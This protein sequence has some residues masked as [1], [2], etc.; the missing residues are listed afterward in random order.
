[1]TTVS[2]SSGTPRERRHEAAQVRLRPAGAAGSRNSAFSRREGAH[3]RDRTVARRWATSTGTSSR[4][5]GATSSRHFAARRAAARRRLR[6]RLAGRP[7]RDYTG[8]T[9]RPKR[10]RRR[11]HVAARSSSST[12]T[13]RCRSRTPSFD[14]VVLKDVLEHVA[15]PVALVR[16]VRRVLRPGRAR[17]SPPRPTR[18]AGS[19]TTTHTGGRS[20]ARRSGC[21]SR[22]RASTSS[23]PATSRSCPAPG[24]CPA[25]RGASAGRAFSRAALAADRPAQRVAGRSQVSVDRARVTRDRGNLD[26][27]LR[28]APQAPRVPGDL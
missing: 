21:C 10:S 2:S 13:S 20:R 15:D 22:T 12:S 24:S 28:S 5:T 7:L 9:G 17:R 1:M 18:S 16:E 11:A 19:G 6:Q 27:N 25:G 26:L 3:G 23:G 14:G 4:A 8:S